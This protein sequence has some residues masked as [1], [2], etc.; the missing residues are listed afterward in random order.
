MKHRL[1]GLGVLVLLALG[2]AWFFLTFDR[3]PVKEHVAP[4]GEARLR[5]FLAAERFAE[6]MGIH[7]RELRSL[8]ELDKLSPGILLVPNRRQSIDAA[9]ASR[10]IAWAQAGNHLVVEAEFVGVDDPLLEALQIKRAG[11][12][13]P[14][15]RPSF[16]DHVSLEAPAVKASLQVG[17]KLVSFP[18]GRGRVTVATSLAFARNRLIGEPGNAELLWQVMALTPAK[19]L[20]VFFHPERLSLT[21]FLVEHAP[22]ALVAAGLL[23]ALWLW[24]IAPRFGPIVPDAPP[25]RRRLLDHLRASGRFFWAHGL[26]ARLVLAA[27]DAALRRIAR[28]QPDFAT[29]SESEKHARLGALVGI[30]PEEAAQFLAAGG[31]MRGHDFI[32]TVQRAQRVHLALERG[33]K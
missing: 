22:L 17:D 5:D 6:R 7:A 13:K 33:G 9:R 27:R 10:L 32:G 19:E 21:G 24:H 8:P 14:Q 28:S 30:P 25:A 1:T 11:Q 20:Q 2:A 29:A 18:R 3:I 12:G 16:P 15:A 31:A 26:R 23:L 4:S